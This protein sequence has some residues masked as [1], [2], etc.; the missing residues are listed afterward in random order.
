MT[1]SDTNRP[2]NS[3]LVN[4]STSGPPRNSSSACLISFSRWASASV[5][6]I[7]AAPGLRRVGNC[8]HPPTSVH[9]WL[10]CQ[11]L[12]GSTNNP[13]PKPPEKHQSPVFKLNRGE[14]AV[15]VLELEIS[16]V[17]GVLVLPGRCRGR[18]AAPLARPAFGTHT[19]RSGPNH[20]FAAAH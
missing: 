1:Q 4:P 2:R 20:F 15:W 18:S 12:G 9:W 6:A 16:L 17:L 10:T 19:A 3:P 13:A 11:R 14:A 5:I 8:S 7:R